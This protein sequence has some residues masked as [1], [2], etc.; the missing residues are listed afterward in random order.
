MSATAERL[1]LL[2]T[3]VDPKIYQVF[4]E[5]LDSRP[6]SMQYVAIQAIDKYIEL[7][8]PT[9]I[10]NDCIELSKT[11]IYVRADICSSNCLEVSKIKLRELNNIISLLFNKKFITGNISYPEKPKTID[12]HNIYK[13]QEIPEKYKKRIKEKTIS[14]DEEFRITLEKTCPKDIA[15]R[16][17]EHVYNFKVIKH[18]RGPINEFLKLIFSE[19]SKW[20]EKPL[21]IEGTLLK[22]RNSLLDKYCRNY[23]YSRYQNV[24]NAINLLIDHKLISSKADL[25]DNLR[26]C[27]KTQKIRVNNPLLCNTYIYDEQKVQSFINTPSFISDLEHELKENIKIIIEFARNKVFEGY[28]KFCKKKSLISDIQLSGLIEIL[29]KMPIN[30]I[31][32]GEFEN[33]IRSRN[34]FSNSELSKTLR[35]NNLVAYY[36]NFYEDFINGESKHKIKGISI[37]EE[38]QE[39]LGLSVGI[40][41]AMQ[42][43]I[44]EELGINP[45]S[46]YNI[47]V[48]SDGHGHEFIRITDDGSVRIRALKLRARNAKTRNAHGSLI[49]LKNIQKQDIDAAACIKMALDMTSRARDYTN[50]KELWLCATKFGI[51][52]PNPETFQN[53]FKKLRINLNHN[54]IALRDATLK[55]IRSSKG[56]LIYLNSKGNSLKT[57]D[58]FGNSVKTTLARYIPSYLTELVFRVKIRNFQNILLFMVLANDES[59]AETLGLSNDDFCSQVKRA[60]ANPDMG[61]SL[62]DSLK[63]KTTEYN[64]NETKYF[65]VSLNNI[66][67][68]LKYLNEGEDINLKEDCKAAIFKISEGPVIMKQLLRQ[69]EKIYKNEKI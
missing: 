25:P 51:I 63:T 34:P 46:L 43:I 6:K 3:Y 27:T 14:K 26:R 65:C 35:T 47:K 10:N 5:Y 61:G 12:E 41:S 45:Y 13:T 44:V 28:K 62:Y 66:I 16:L 20:Y 2:S 40:A 57:A 33:N 32:E 23:S 39:H 15:E 38:V 37:N 19:D 7:L 18:H 67:L 22:Y 49:D 8:L 68:A 54:N 52:H 69:A 56:V 4:S 48:Y 42:I 64:T 55:K 58:Y 36:D 29:E 60:F 30:R 50:K 11:L 53:A 21:L 31:D 1:N 17:K 24:K 9:I 59:Q